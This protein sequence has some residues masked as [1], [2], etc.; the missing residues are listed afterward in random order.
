[1]SSRRLDSPDAEPG[2]QDHK[3]Y[4]EFKDSRALCREHEAGV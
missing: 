1:M 4:V 3:T 2:I